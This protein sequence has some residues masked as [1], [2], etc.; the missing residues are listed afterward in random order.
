MRVLVCGGRDWSDWATLDHALEA[1]H[2]EAPIL[3]IIEGGASGADSLA[4]EW[5]SAYDIPEHLMFAADWRTH[6]KRA[7]PIRNQR[8][9]DEGKPDLV[10]AFP[11]G[12]GTSDM[13]RRA[14]AAGVRVIEVA[15]PLPCCEIEKR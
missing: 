8:M 3:C 15:P 11:G 9:I 1:L 5:A 13:V 14:K 4:N 10:V 12:R 6:G 2:S 7:G